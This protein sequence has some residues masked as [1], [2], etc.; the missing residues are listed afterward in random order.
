MR[1][2]LLRVR[3]RFGAPQGRFLSTE[4]Q[5]TGMIARQK[6]VECRFLPIFLSTGRLGGHEEMGDG[7]RR[8]R[9]PNGRRTSKRQATVRICEIL[10]PR[11]GSKRSSLEQPG[12][13][14]R[15]RRLTSRKLRPNPLGGGQHAKIR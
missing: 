4:C 9:N 10:R 12:K 7:V 2:G 14:K 1:R 13:L 6:A 15:T 11:R 3:R 8:P 5:R